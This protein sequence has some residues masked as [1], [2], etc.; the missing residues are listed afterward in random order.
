LLNLA[1]STKVLSAIASVY[2]G[3]SIFSRLDTGVFLSA[4]A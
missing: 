3:K 2:R 4:S 1:G